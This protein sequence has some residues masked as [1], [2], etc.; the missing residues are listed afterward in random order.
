MIETFTLGAFL[1][2]AINFVRSKRSFEDRFGHL[3]F[4]LLFIVCYGFCL[5]LI[6]PEFQLHSFNLSYFKLGFLISFLVACVLKLGLYVSISSLFSRNYKNKFIKITLVE[7]FCL[8]LFVFLG[9]AFE[10]LILSNFLIITWSILTRPV[11]SKSKSKVVVYAAGNVVALKGLEDN[12]QLAVCPIDRIRMKK[13][14]LS[15]TPL[16]IG[17]KV[18]LLVQVMLTAH[19]FYQVLDN[20]DSIFIHEILMYG[21][22]FILSISS[23]GRVVE[24]R[25]L[26]VSEVVRHILFIIIETSYWKN[27]YGVEI[28]KANLNIVLISLM[29]FNWYLLINSSQVLKR[30][31]K[32]F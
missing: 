18:Y 28:F 8:P 25:S 26:V 3:L 15:K 16:D 22:Y 11:Q 30:L 23:L 32:I 21:L 13:L 1:I 27:P 2:L 17:L 12:E 9:V 14:K 19:I 24:K 6:R 4:Y 31:K 5:K 29:S 10:D 7:L 20:F